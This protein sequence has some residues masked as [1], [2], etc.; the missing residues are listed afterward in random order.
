[1]KKTFDCVHHF[2]QA[3]KSAGLPDIRV[4]DLRHSHASLLLASGV[5]PKLGQERLGQASIT[6]TLNT[7]SHVI[8]SLQEEVAR[9]MDDLMN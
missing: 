9:K 1:M 2:K 8:P 3:L 6:F 4:H 7:C 5:N